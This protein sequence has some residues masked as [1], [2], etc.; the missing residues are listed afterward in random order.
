MPTDKEPNC[1]SEDITASMVISESDHCSVV[2]KGLR[3]VILTESGEQSHLRV[4]APF[5]RQKESIHYGHCQID[6]W[7]LR[8]RSRLKFP[9]QNIQCIFPSRPP[10]E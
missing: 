5:Y 7:W 6:S 10:L 2:Y 4:E 8:Q 1:V 3:Y 9:T